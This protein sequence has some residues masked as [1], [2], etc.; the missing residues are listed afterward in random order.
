MRNLKMTIAYD[1]SRYKGWQK[2]KDTDLTIQGK[3]EAV[4][5][6]M[7]EEN[8]LLVGCG[9]TDLGVHAENYIANFHTKCAMS[10]DTMMDYL[11]Q[12]LPEDIV[13]KSMV[14]VD[15]RF[16]ARYNVKSKTYVYK[17]NNNKYRDVFNRKYTYHLAE[18]L[19]LTEMRKAS[20]ALIGSHDFQSFINSKSKNKSTIRTINYINIIEH[21][22]NIDIEVNGDGFLWNMVRIIAGTLIE[23]GKGNLEASNVEKILNEKKR[24]EAGPLAQAKG[25]LLRDVQY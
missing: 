5:S 24:W 4:L 3:I 10:S 17:I 15:E 6:K 23:V 7:T 16:H 19:N 18:K 1:G 12:F 14:D 20:D 25:L 8:V 22:G 9:R 21:D 11:Y 2:Q 13:V